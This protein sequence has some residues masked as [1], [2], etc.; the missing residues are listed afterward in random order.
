MPPDH[1]R[2]L[3]ADPCKSAS[4]AARNHIAFGADTGGVGIT[5]VL[6][7]VVEAALALSNTSAG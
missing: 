7:L 3:S 5:V 4:F 2:R 1:R 6:Q